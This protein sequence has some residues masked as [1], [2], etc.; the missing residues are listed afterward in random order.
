[1]IDYVDST[2][3][4]TQKYIAKL[5]QEIGDWNMDSTSNIYVYFNHAITYA[6]IRKI[7][8][9]IKY[10]AGTEYTPLNY[11]YDTTDPSLLNGGIDYITAT[12][13]ILRR[14][15]G[16]QFDSANFDSTSYNRGYVLIE[17]ET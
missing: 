10:D 15:T 17:W 6:N 11:F 16:G 4:R 5:D 1:M 3:A 7:D 8:V 13:V 2:G 14:R 12:Y 9:M